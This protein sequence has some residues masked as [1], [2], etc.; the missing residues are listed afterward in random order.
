MNKT[1]LWSMAIMGAL[2]ATVTSCSNELVAP[3]ADGSLVNVQITASV[4]NAQIL[5]RGDSRALSD[6]K[7]VNQ[8]TYAVY[9]G[10]YTSSTIGEPLAIFT[11]ADN[12]ATVQKTESVDMTGDKLEHT[13]QLQ[14]AKGETYT[15]VFWAD[16]QTDNVSPYTFDATDK[17]VTVSYE[18][19]LANDASRDAFFGIGT[20]TA[21]SGTSQSV[22]LTRQLALVNLATNDVNEYKASMGSFDKS[23]ITVKHAANQLNFFNA[24]TPTEGDVTAT[25]SLNTLPTD[26]TPIADY[27]YL[28]YAFVL[29]A[30]TVDVT[31]GVGTGSNG[32]ELNTVNSAPVKANYRTN[33][34]GSLLTDQYNVTTTITPAYTGNENF[35]VWDGVSVDEPTV[36]TKDQTIT[37][38]SPSEFIGLLNLIN[39]GSASGIRSRAT[40]TSYEGYTI[41]L[42]ASFDFAGHE[43]TPIANGVT[44]NGKTIAGTPFKGAI[45]GQ[46]HTLKNFTITEPTSNTNTN[47]AIGFIAG[48]SGENA[49]LRN[50]NFSDIKIT[51]ATTAQQTAIVALL[52]DNAKVTNVHILSGTISG[53]QSV[54]GIVGRLIINGTISNC[55]NAATIT[56]SA[57]NIAG[58]VG[59]AYYSAKGYNM[60][61]DNCTNTGAIKG[62]SVV[63]GIA[64]LSCATI[65]DCENNGA[66]TGTNGSSVGGI[67]GEQQNGGSISRCKNT[68]N[69]TKGDNYGAGGIVGWIRYHGATSSYPSKNIIEV[70]DCTNSGNISNTGSGS[71]GIVGVCYHY[72]NIHNCV[73]TAQTITAGEFASGIVGGVQTSDGTS[74][75]VGTDSFG[76]YKVYVRYNV[77]TTTD[78]GNSSC[79]GLYVY[80]NDINTGTPTV[81]TTDDEGNETNS[82]TLNSAE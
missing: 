57:S 69:V 58:I 30:S 78:F 3:D 52:T 36:N 17:K 55:S 39:S 14:L 65:T 42:N 68:A 32:T 11:G 63:G 8:I 72:G 62:L 45:D 77:S 66:I 41:T 67:A 74:G 54:A 79:S 51:S 28:G 40:D 7:N 75:P 48:L 10:D 1:S 81:V 25:F 19:A 34:Y 47:L 49:E 6:G 59:A 24:Q 50:L 5:S 44:R 60:V 16:Q 12:A 33:I 37:V 21:G 27:S 15:I 13:V 18:N 43:I 80:D 61:I 9:A 4:Q 38:N 82:S 35:I 53:I 46:G 2:V 31:Y 64:G 56:G 76:V 70:S 22:T 73:N 71:G 26:D 20:L 29:P 23:L